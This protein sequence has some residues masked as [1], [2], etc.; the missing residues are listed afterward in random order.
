[1]STLADSTDRSSVDCVHFGLVFAGFLLS[2]T[3]VVLTCL[4]LM[5]A[6]ILITIVGLGYFL[7]RSRCDPG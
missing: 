6:G 3:G 4:G 5:I 2:A 1:M 7:L